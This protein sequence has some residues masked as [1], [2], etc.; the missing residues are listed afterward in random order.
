MSNFRPF[1]LAFAILATAV[2][3]L[4]AGPAFAHAKLLSESPAAED[5]TAPQPAP[6]PPTDLRLSFSE[7]LNLAF[8][9]LIVTDSSGK[10]IVLGALALDANDDKVLVGP[11]V[12][13][14]TLGEY[15]VDW[16]VVSNDGHKST[17]SYTFKAE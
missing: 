15:K 4:A 7:G 9:K 1:R 6:S 12:D 17:G 11:L 8:C 10:A 5:A 16:T 13:Q 3:A 2:L 14:L